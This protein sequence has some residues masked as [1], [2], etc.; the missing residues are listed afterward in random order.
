MIL[1]WFACKERVQKLLVV[2]A[3]ASNVGHLVLNLDF[4]VS[5]YVVYTMQI[6]CTLHTLV[7]VVW[8]SGLIVWDPCIFCMWRL[9][10]LLVL[11][12]GGFLFLSIADL[13][14]T[15]FPWLE[16]WTTMLFNFSIRFVASYINIWLVFA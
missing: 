4:D 8:I 9:N 13:F 14:A 1:I 11:G 10:D 6:E 5:G 12:H 2:L 3:R 7:I 15:S 16:S